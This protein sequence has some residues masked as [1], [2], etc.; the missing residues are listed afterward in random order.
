MV[1][2]ND[3]LKVCTEEDWPELLKLHHQMEKELSEVSTLDLQADTG[4]NERC[5]RR[6]ATNTSRGM[7]AKSN[8][9]GKSQDVTAGSQ[10][11][12]PPLKEMTPLAVTNANSRKRKRGPRSMAVNTDSE[13][14][15]RLSADDT[16]R[17]KP[18][19]KPKLKAGGSKVEGAIKEESEPDS[20]NSN[21][22]TRSET[23][24]EQ[25]SASKK[26]SDD[27]DR[28]GGPSTSSN[29]T[30][31]GRRRRSAVVTP[32]VCTKLLLATQEK[33][34][35]VLTSKDQRSKEDWEKVINLQLPPLMPAERR[36]LV[37]GHSKRGL[38]NWVTVII[39]NAWNR[40]SEHKRTGR[41]LKELVIEDIAK[42]K[43]RRSFDPDFLELVFKEF[44]FDDEQTDDP[45]RWLD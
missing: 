1:K 29:G 45:F 14:N 9:S 8:P 21:Y 4:Y 13:E 36:A 41:P 18:A 31:R 24:K 3:E 26:S 5:R 28:D 42:W 16:K 12:P 34:I 6:K 37:R 30:P 38:C 23:W 11:T 40:L 43:E 15:D 19:T 44:P 7:I 27:T 22:K 2:T 39:D 20:G 25:G 35:T 10:G 32:P 33:I 17:A